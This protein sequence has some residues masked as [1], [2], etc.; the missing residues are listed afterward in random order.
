M[1][2]IGLPEFKNLGIEN[3]YQ[4][5]STEDYFALRRG[6][7]IEIDKIPDHLVDGGFVEKIEGE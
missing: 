7:I 4:G 6:E 5:L 3:D 1:K 2:I